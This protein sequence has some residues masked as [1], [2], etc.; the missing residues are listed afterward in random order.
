MASSLSGVGSTVALEQPQN[1]ADTDLA[2]ALTRHRRGQGQEL[3][4]DSALKQWALSR[5][6]KLSFGLYKMQLQLLRNR[7]KM[8]ADNVDRAT[9]NLPTQAVSGLGASKLATRFIGPFMV[10]ERHSSAYTLELPSDMI[11]HPA[12]YVGHLKP[13]VLPESSSRDDSPTTTHGGTSAFRQTSSPPRE[14]GISAEWRSK[15][16]LHAH[17]WYLQWRA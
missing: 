3:D 4:P 15:L 14:K 6:G 11:L 9:Q 16:F 12:F 17:S 1:T 5:N 10:A 2:A 13:N 8:N 7:Q